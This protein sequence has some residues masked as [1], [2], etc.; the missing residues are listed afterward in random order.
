MLQMGKLDNAITDFNKSIAL[1]PNR[2]E[3]FRNR[4]RYW[5]AKG[6]YYQAIN[7][8]REAMKLDPEYV[9]AITSLA[10]FHA[11]CPVDR[12][13]DG[14]RALQLATEACRMTNERD[15]A[16]LAALATAQAALG[17][18]ADALKSQM[19]SLELAPEN[20]KERLREDLK[21][22]EAGRALHVTPTADNQR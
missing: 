17:Q 10:W 20:E 12:Y 8:Y 3:S 21:T 5:T 9:P 1:D 14:K 7:D 18:K 19:K 13:R 22:F 15:Y 4:A 2:P 16:S 6:I 11:T